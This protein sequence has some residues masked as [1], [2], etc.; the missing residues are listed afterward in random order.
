MAARLDIVGG[1]C[2]EKRAAAFA[3]DRAARPV[4]RARPGGPVLRA[5]LEALL[6]ARVAAPFFAARL[7]ELFVLRLGDEPLTCSGCCC[8]FA[9]R[10]SA[11]RSKGTSSTHDLAGQRC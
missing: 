8:A 3:V 10:S 5:E 4:L 11:A 1:I 9:C 6:R 2:D 7:R